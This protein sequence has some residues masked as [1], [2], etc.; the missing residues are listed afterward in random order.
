VGNEILAFD[1]YLVEEF[2]LK[3]LREIAEAGGEK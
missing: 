1:Q 2:L 3:Q